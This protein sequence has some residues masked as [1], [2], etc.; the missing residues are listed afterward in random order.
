MIVGASDSIGVFI[1]RNLGPL[2]KTLIRDMRTNVLGVDASGNGNATLVNN[3][4][5]QET[6]TA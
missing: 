1:M 6:E 2:D 5:D 4:G 3:S